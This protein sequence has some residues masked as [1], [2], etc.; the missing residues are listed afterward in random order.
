MVSR[1]EI[2]LFF[3]IFQLG[4]FFFSLAMEEIE[5]EIFEEMDNGYG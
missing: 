3:F 4:N 5:E 1:L 2:E